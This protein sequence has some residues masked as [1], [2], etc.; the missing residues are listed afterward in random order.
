MTTDIFCFYLQNRQ[1][2]TGQTGGQRYSDTSPPFSIPCLRQRLG[3]ARRSSRDK[4]IAVNYVRKKF[5]KTETR[6]QCYKTF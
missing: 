6:A 4:L 1:L 3:N 5:Y 2:Q